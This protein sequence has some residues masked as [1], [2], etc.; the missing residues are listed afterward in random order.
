MSSPSTLTS[1][2][3]TGFMAG[4]VSAFPVV[5]SNFAPWRGHFI[6]LPINSPWSRGPASW[7]HTSSMAW[8]SPSTLQSATRWP[9]SSY[10]PT[11]PGATSPILAILWYSLI[12]LRHTLLEAKPDL[13]LYSPVELVLQ[14]L[15][16]DPARD[17]PEETEDH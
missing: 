9:S 11:S 12:R 13:T 5:T 14:S 8:N 4:R 1:C 2:L 7:V 6:W 3:G 16:G 15:E 17:L 10:T